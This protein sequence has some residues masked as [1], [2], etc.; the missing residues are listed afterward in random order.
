MMCDRTADGDPTS[1][2]RGACSHRDGH[3][4]VG[5]GEYRRRPGGGRQQNHTTGLGAGLLMLMP[6]AFLRAH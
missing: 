5:N 1:G 3:L 2:M 4:T 6:L